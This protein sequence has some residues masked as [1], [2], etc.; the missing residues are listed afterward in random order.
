M[1]NTWGVMIQYF[2]GRY[3]SFVS[4]DSLYRGIKELMPR[5]GICFIA[6]TPGVSGE[7][8]DSVMGGINRIVRRL[9]DNEQVDLRKELEQII[10]DPE[11]AKPDSCQTNAPPQPL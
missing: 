1:S 10:K 3:N 6:G 8:I 9:N 7:K 4:D 5:H 2:G 11:I